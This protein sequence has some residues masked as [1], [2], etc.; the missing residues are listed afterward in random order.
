MTSI[1]SHPRTSSTQAYG[2]SPTHV[3]THAHT[4]SPRR[5]MA[6][7]QTSTPCRHTRTRSQALRPAGRSGTQNVLEASPVDTALTH[8]LQLGYFKKSFSVRTCC[9]RLNPA[10]THPTHTHVG[11][12]ARR[13]RAEHLL[14]GPVGERSRRH[15]Q[16][17]ARAKYPVTNAVSKLPLLKSVS[18]FRNKN[19]L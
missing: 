6:R 8:P 10:D 18:S 16:I 4:P 9:L 1:P 13:G 14:L 5:H 15:T 11:A 3:H 17:R 2:S 19:P 12:H 7:T